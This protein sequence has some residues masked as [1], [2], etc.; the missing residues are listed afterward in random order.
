VFPIPPSQ[1]AP[2]MQAEEENA[3]L[4]EELAH[5]RGDSR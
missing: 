1:D 5:L 2:L 3:R 4:R